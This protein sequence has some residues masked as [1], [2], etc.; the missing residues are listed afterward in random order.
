MLSSRRRAA[1]AAWV[2]YQ[3]KADEQPFCYGLRS[4]GQ[5]ASLLVSGRAAE[6]SCD[7]PR[8]CRSR[9]HS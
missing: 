4:S 5:G 2:A 9:I 3:A 7:G 1:V 8:P 6:D